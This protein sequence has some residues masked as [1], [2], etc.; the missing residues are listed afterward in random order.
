MRMY[1]VNTGF[2]SVNNQTAGRFI[3]RRSVSA[4]AVIEAIVLGEIQLLAEV[5]DASAKY[6]PL[7]NPLRCQRLEIIVS[8]LSRVLTII[9]WLIII[10]EGASR[11]AVRVQRLHRW[12]RPRRSA[13]SPL[14][15]DT[16]AVVLRARCNFDQN[17]SPRVVRSHAYNDQCN[18]FMR[19]VIKLVRHLNLSHLL[20]KLILIH[21]Y[22]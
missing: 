22:N 20:S 2:I 4:C 19:P 13:T 8:D 15:C 3:R 11:V 7:G 14:R 17:G 10:I 9:K 6:R 12:H 18:S 21:D 1:P 16:G 5:E